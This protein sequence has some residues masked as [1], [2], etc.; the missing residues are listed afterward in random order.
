MSADR[1]HLTLAGLRGLPWPPLP[2]L[3]G[4]VHVCRDAPLSAA[5]LALCAGISKQAAH[6]RLKA[7]A[8]LLDADDTTD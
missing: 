1:W 2:E 8:R 3:Q 6:Q 7:R 4:V 5:E